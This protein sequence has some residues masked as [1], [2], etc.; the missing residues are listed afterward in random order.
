MT[1]G[2]FE[3]PFLSFAARSANNPGVTVEKAN[4]SARGPALTPFRGCKLALTPGSSSAPDAHLK[5]ECWLVASGEGL[6]SYNGREYRVAP[7]DFLYFEPNLSHQVTNDGQ[8][9]LLIFALWWTP[10]N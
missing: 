9:E 1:I 8:E 6:L 7:G 4:F 10:E 2:C 5:R 3:S